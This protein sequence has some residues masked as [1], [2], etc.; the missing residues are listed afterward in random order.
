VGNGVN[1]G[2]MVGMMVGVYVGYG[3]YVGSGVY[4]AKIIGVGVDILL[5]ASAILA[6]TV[7]SIFC[8]LSFAMQLT[9][10]NVIKSK[11]AK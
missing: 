3:V 8:V 4:V 6:T 9:K 11:H 1:V 7:D 2:V 5:K 10:L